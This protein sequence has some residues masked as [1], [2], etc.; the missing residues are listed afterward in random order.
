MIPVLVAVPLL[1]AFMTVLVDTVIRSRRIRAGMVPLLYISGS[2]LPWPVLLVSY[3][4]T[5]VDEIVGGWT[6]AGGIEV[7]LNGYN[8][9]FILG[10]LILFSAVSIYS[11]G[12]F[13]TGK[14]YSVIL[15][16]EAGVLGA[17]ISRDLFNYYIYMEIASVCAF[18]LT[19]L[20]DE[21][22]AR[23]A[24]FRYLVFSL[25]ASYLFIFATGI[26]YLKTGYLNLELI[27]QTA[28]PSREIITAVGMAFSA[29]LLKAGVFPLHFWLPDA[30]S[31][32][33]TPA[34]ALLSG[35]VV[36]VPVYGMLLL[37]Y[38]LP[39]GPVMRNALTVVAFLSIFG[40]IAGALFQI[41]A[42]RLLA[43]STVSQLGYILLGLSTGSIYG[44]IY[45]SLAHMLFKGG[46]FLSVGSLADAQG[47]KN[48]RELSYRGNRGV[49]AALLLLS[50]ALPG[51]SPFIT[52]Y[53]KKLILSGLSWPGVP[54]LY[55]AT[56]GTMLYIIKLNYHLAGPG[57]RGSVK[58]PVSL[59]LGLLTLIS[60]IYLSPS[61]N[62]ADWMLL[63]LT[64][65]V[66]M[67]LRKTGILEKTLHLTLAGE[68]GREVNMQMMLFFLF[69]LG[70]MLIQGL[71]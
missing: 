57:K 4:G 18:I 55:A 42:K 37:F 60:G 59:I 22:G 13:R 39:V 52:A 17:F 21:E 6:R 24:A 58:A 66:F 50:L 65:V 9:Y 63:L 7:A 16:M 35:V 68:F 12:H 33:S 11:A 45:Y 36:K 14:E 48:M 2:L 54:L 38:A 70:M 64:S 49:M 29:L 67:L 31:R 61:L 27:R 25:T 44:A 40:G 19:A 62:P 32:A 41:N 47:T 1:F 20:S 53:G 56:A 3:K 46:L 69:V 34:S 51:I 8:F 5:P 23:K 43:Y 15:L 28:R 10:A 26:I 71:Q 30:H